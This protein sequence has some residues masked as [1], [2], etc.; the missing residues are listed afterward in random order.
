MDQSVKLSPEILA[1]IKDV[2]HNVNT[3]AMSRMMS[4]LRDNIVNKQ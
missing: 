2:I 3:S 1:H 4:R